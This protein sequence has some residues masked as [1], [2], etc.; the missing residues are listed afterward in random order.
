MTFSFAMHY[1]IWKFIFAI[2]GPKLARSGVENRLIKHKIVF[3]NVHHWEKSQGLWEDFE[4]AFIHNQA[5][6]NEHLENY[7]FINLKL[8]INRYELDF[9]L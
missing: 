9:I 6:L 4:K 2:K 8:S 1:K 5:H 3:F 7:I